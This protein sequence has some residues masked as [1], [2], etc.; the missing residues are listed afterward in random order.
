MDPP[1]NT[2]SDFIKSQK[3]NGGSQKQVYDISLKVNLTWCY[4]HVNI[5]CLAAECL[6]YNKHRIII[7]SNPRGI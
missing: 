5:I 3:S 2:Y 6:A 4:L 7:T 1:E